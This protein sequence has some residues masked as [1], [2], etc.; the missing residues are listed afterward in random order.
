MIYIDSPLGTGF[1]YSDYPGNAVNSTP[2]AV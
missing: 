2:M 1:S